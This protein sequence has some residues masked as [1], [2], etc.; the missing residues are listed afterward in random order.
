MSS[1]VEEFFFERGIK[2]A[3]NILYILWECS[4]TAVNM[5]CSS[6]HKLRNLSYSV[7]SVPSLNLHQLDLFFFVEQIFTL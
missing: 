2:D 5:T 3:Y 4:E 7:W 6:R 1:V